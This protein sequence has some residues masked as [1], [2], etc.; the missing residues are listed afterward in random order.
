MNGRTSLTPGPDT[1]LP[2]P[3]PQAQQAQQAQQPNVF[4]GNPV[5]DLLRMLRMIAWRML[6][7]LLRQ[8]AKK[9]VAKSTVWRMLRMLRT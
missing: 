8:Q 5:A 7:M 1:S 4:K 6:R 2:R 9:T 3:L